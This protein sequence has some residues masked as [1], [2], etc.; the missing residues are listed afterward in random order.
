MKANLTNKLSCFTSKKDFY[1]NKPRKRF[2]VKRDSVPRL[3]LYLNIKR[4]GGFQM[5]RNNPAPS[6][7][8]GQMSD[9]DNLNIG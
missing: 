8:I 6:S 9:P 7:H 3:Q 1:M 2:R 5:E 4:S